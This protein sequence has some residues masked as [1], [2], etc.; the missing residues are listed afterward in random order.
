MYTG[1]V[2]G[3]A[4]IVGGFLAAL[5]GFQLLLVA[6][7][8]APASRAERALRRSPGW[9]ALTGAGI[10]LFTAV[11]A[12]IVMPAVGELGGLGKL[13]NA[14]FAGLFTIPLILG[15]AAVSREVGARMP[16]PADL[17][18]PW[19]ATL[20]GAVTCELA[21]TTPFVGWFLVL[22]A[23]L[24]AGLG[25]VVLGLVRRES[26]DAAPSARPASEPSVSA[27]A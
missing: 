18:R 20:R 6:L 8:P 14:M 17:G 9:C 2:W 12:R 27:V 7:F 23:A 5:T 10:L 15:L 19:R 21:F 4:L 1:N 13:A 16:S 24:C 25:A 11:A 3:I 22:P 26:A